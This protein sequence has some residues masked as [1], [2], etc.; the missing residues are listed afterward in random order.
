MSGLSIHSDEHYMKLALQEAQEAYDEGEVPVGAVIVCEN[1]VIAKDH[2]R[3]VRLNDATAHAEMLALTSAQNYL[4]S[5]YLNECT[6]YVT[7][8]PC[9][10]CGGALFWTQIGKIV[11]G[12]LDEKRGFSTY[13]ENI[14]H[15]KTVIQTGVMRTEC[16]AIIK[17]FFKNMRSS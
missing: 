13:N 5:R 7:L 12:A 1:K 9:I 16:E 17:D 11:V 6:M 3:S 4:N 2:N 10:M 8:E 15:P 14:I